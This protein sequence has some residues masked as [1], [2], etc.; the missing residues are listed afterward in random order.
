MLLLILIHPQN[1]ESISSSV[2][3]S[4]IDQ[5]ERLDLNCSN[6]VEMVNSWLEVNN[7]IRLISDKRERRAACKKLEESVLSVDLMRKTDYQKSCLVGVY[8]HILHL[9]GRNMLE[10]GFPDSEIHNYIIKGWLKYRDMCFS[11][12]NENDFSDGNGIKARN[13]R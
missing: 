9:L 12:G 8:W 7:T 13:R 4:L 3:T 6:S 10:S 2:A 1:N 5:I 11:F